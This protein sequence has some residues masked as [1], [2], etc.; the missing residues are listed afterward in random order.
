MYVASLTGWLGFLLIGATISLPYIVRKPLAANSA[1]PA[2]KGNA[3]FLDGMRPHAYLGYII[4][5]LVVGHA[6]LAMTAATMS[7]SNQTGIWLA[8]LALIAIV[9]QAAVGRQ[10]LER[11]CPQRRTLRG[12]HFWTMAAV[13]ILVLGHTLLNGSM[14]QTTGQ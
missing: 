6:Y 11:Q 4:L 5:A 8:M 9:A 2:P 14:L 10:L 7:R 12:Y 13:V 3:S 1:R